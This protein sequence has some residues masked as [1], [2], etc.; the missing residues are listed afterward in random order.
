MSTRGSCYSFA[1]VLDRL[2][3]HGYIV[4]TTKRRAQAVAASLATSPLIRVS[5]GQLTAG[6]GVFNGNQRMGC[7]RPKRGFHPRSNPSTEWQHRRYYNGTTCRTLN[8]TVLGF[9]VDETLSGR[10]FVRENRFYVPATLTSRHISAIT[11][12]YGAEG[13]THQDF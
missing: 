12:V 10:Y 4:L 13:A 9:L 7:G 6:L 3:T 1:R 2:A 8:Q 5:D 11:P